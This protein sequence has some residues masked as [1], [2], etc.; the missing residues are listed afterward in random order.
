MELKHGYMIAVPTRKGFKSPQA[1]LF[2]SKSEAI[3]NYLKSNGIRVSKLSRRER[4]RIW[5]TFRRN[6]ICAMSVAA[7]PK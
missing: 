4:D 6:G 3:S 7:V 5:K 1:T 2:R